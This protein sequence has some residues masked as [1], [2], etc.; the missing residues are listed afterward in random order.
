MLQNM[1]SDMNKLIN[2]T[3]QMG[4]EISI[5]GETMVITFT[6]STIMKAARIQAMSLGYSTSSEDTTL[7]IDQSE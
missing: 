3:I 5:E 4:G 2:F 1:R 7:K 6:N